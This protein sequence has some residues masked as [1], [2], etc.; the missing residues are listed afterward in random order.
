MLNFYEYGYG[1]DKEDVYKHPIS[2]MTS[3]LYMHTYYPEIEHIIK[4]DPGT[5]YWCSKFIKKGRWIEAEP[6]I[7]KDPKWAVWYARDVINGRWL[8][9]EP[10]IKKTPSW[11]AYYEGNFRVKL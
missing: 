8:E 2:H 5:A 4:K 9:A 6:I 7:M 11:C 1:L 3:V 10:F